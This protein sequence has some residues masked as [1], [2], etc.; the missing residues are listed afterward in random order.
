MPPINS[1]EEVTSSTQ[2]LDA[3]A[4]LNGASLNR[5]RWAPR[6]ILYFLLII[7]VLHTLLTGCPIPLWRI[8]HLNSPNEV[9]AV[10]RSE[11]ILRGGRAV[12]LPF[13]KELPPNNPLFQAA[14]ASGVEISE[15][16]KLHGLMWVDRSCG[17]DPVVWRRMRVDLSELAAALHPLGIDEAVVHPDTIAVLAT[18]DLFRIDLTQPS[19]SHRRGRLN[20]FDL[21]RM[22][23]IRRQI[24]DSAGMAK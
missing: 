22:G 11:L 13:I 14:L 6:V 20:D 10:G 7:S 9:T 1:A 23:M 24:E 16:G 2:V 4:M 15:S 3:S 17:N 18:G 19:R 21:S 12:A 8:E 5:L